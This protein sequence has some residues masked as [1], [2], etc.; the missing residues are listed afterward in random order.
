[1]KV[2]TYR[3]STMKQALEE[4]K[5]ELGH[6]AF[7]LSG[8]EV[9]GKKMLGLFGKTCFEVTAAVDYAGSAPKA[10]RS[11][12][13]AAPA[14]RPSPA[15]PIELDE[16]QDTFKFSFPTPKR[17]SLAMARPAANAA[18]AFQP[19][20]ALSERKHEIE[21]GGL[22]EEIRQL[23][24][25]V[26]SLPR[27]TVPRP[28]LVSRPA[29]FAHRVYEEVYQD[30]RARELDDDLACELMDAAIKERKPTAA[31]NKRQMLRR[32][33]GYLAR[34]IH[35]SDAV[36]HVPQAGVQSI[37]ALLG[38]TGVGK[39]TTL[40]KL[41]ARAV[42]EQRSK[43]GF[44]TVDTF[45]IAATEQLKTYAEIIDVPTR[46]VENLRGIPQA[47]AEFADRDL[48]LIDTAGRSPRDRTSLQELAGALNELPNVQKTLLLSATTKRSD[49]ADIAERHAVFNPSS[50]IFTK[51]DE[52]QVYGPVLSQLVRTASPLAYLTIG[53]N[54]PKDIVVPDASHITRLFDG[55][56]VSSWE[57]SQPTPAAALLAPASRRKAGRSQNSLIQTEVNS[58]A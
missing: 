50:L 8:K 26:Q 35:L 9:K 54:V 4:I 14:K 7:I 29:K 23:R 31:P 3:A 41:A 6:D 43:V 57:R 25:I 32:I 1:M 28:P 5:K 15:D 2:K 27:Q 16:I 22:A 52:T 17:G 45:R 36:L 18:V 49:L 56:D 55:G 30:L 37:L 33:A 42:L 11:T 20:L 21:P 51:L 53:Q 34:R 13:E 12:S 40:A 10:A 24:A 44:I 19:A 47:I 39:T 58:N 48:I 46:I 38:P